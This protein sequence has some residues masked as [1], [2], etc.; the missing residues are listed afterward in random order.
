MWC[1][2]LDGCYANIADSVRLFKVFDFSALQAPIQLTIQ[3]W[4][5]GTGADNA[6]VKIAERPI[7]N[8]NT[9]GGGRPWQNRT[10]TN[11]PFINGLAGQT[12]VV[13]ELG[14]MTGP[15]WNEL[16]HYVTNVGI[17]GCK[18]AGGGG[19]PGT[20]VPTASEWGLIFLALILVNLSLIL[21]RQGSIA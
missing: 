11:D 17:R 16:G 20:P 12:G 15:N 6:Y 21:R 9:P 18:S 8:A 10:W 14:M 5:S 2:N 1:T 7:W 13:L 4:W 19:N 3:H